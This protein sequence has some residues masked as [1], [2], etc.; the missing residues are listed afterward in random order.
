MFASPTFSGTVTL[1][2]VGNVSITGGT[3]GQVLTTNG[4]GVLSWATVSGGS[5][6]NTFTTISVAGQSDVVADTTSDTLTLVAGTGISITTTAGSDTISIASTVSAGATNLD[7]LSDVTITSVATGQILLYTGSNFVN[8]SSRLFHQFAYP[9]ITALD[10]TNSGSTAYLFNNQYAGNNP[11]IYAISGT[12]IAFNLN[13]SG[14]P[15]LIRTS[16]GA[17]YNTGLIHVDVD[18]TVST[19]SSAQGKTAGTLY[20]QIPAGTT[21]NYQYICSIHSGMVGVITIKSIS[22]MA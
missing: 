1:G 10:V 22:A 18:G 9:A 11:T 21:G 13:V 8:Y 16:G 2:A 4:S 14:H 15:F 12:T 19:G 5:S 20:W 17:N 3:T 6:S 7:G